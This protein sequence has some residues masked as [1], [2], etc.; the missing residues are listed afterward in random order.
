MRSRTA[1]ALGSIFPH[2]PNKQHAWD[3]LIKLSTDE[4]HS[5][6][7]CANHSLGKVSIFKASQAE[8]EAD[9]KKELE[10]AIVF[11]EK[12][13]RESHG[14][15][16]PSNFC[17][18]F[19]RSFHTIIFKRQGAKEEMDRYLAEAKS[20]I[21]GSKSKELLLEAVENLSNALR[22][23]QNLGNLDLDEV[24]PKLTKTL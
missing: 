21:E 4:D 1:Y 3:D 11:F 18:P 24:L 23:V 8:E 20:A 22:E 15:F 9:Y 19:Y 17:L 10:K 2:V 14:W 12:A 5:V 6:I 13:T 7:T 16:N